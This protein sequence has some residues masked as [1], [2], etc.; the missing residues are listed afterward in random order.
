MKQ[1]TRGNKSAITSLTH[2]GESVSLGITHEVLCKERQDHRKKAQTH[3][4]NLVNQI[5]IDR[6]T[7]VEFENY[8]GGRG[9]NEK[10]SDH[11]IEP[12]G[13]RLH[14]NRFNFKPHNEHAVPVVYVGDSKR[15]F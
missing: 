5:S 1:D 9:V 3:I 2:D 6:S 8:P 11:P 15:S 4:G 10:Y 14:G 7:I 13:S 12:T